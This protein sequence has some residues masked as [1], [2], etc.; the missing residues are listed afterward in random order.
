MRLE[1]CTLDNRATHKDHQ[2][3]RFEKRTGFPA[4]TFILL[5]FLGE[6]QNIDLTKHAL[7]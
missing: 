7:K 4:Q 6:C 3:I 2:F 1:T 5:C